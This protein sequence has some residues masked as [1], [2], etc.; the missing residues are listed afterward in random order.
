M[1]R[2]SWRACAALS[3]LNLATAVPAENP[4]SVILDDVGQG[5][6]LAKTAVDGLFA[7]MPRLKTAVTIEVS[8]LISRTKVEQSFANPHEL[9]LEALYVFPLPEGVVV[10]TLKLRVGDREI[11]GEIEERSQAQKSYEAAKAAGQRAALVEQAR[12][13]LFTTA[14]ANL[15]PGE[16]VTVHLEY[17]ATLR[18]DSGLFELRFPMTVTPRY[19]AAGSAVL[20]QTSG[21]ASPLFESIREL[22]TELSRTEVELEVDLG[23]P[24]EHVESPSHQLAIERRRGTNYHIVPFLQ[25]GKNLPADRDLVI[26]LRPERGTMPRVALY[27]ETFGRDTY[28]ELLVIPP[29][30][31]VVSGVRL[32]RETIFILDTSGSMSGE[33]LRA[34]KAAL[35]N[36]LGRLPPADH[37]NVIDFDS[38]ATRAFEASQPAEAEA[39][40]EAQAFIE[41]LEA[42]GGT[43]MLAALRLALEESAPLP[44]ALQ[45]IIFITDGSVDNEAA[46]FQYL[47]NRLGPARLFTVGIG[48][49]PNS[50]FLRRAAE[51]GRGTATFITDLSDVESRMGLLLGKLE[52]PLLAD[53][54]VLWYDP[55]TQSLPD[56]IPDLYHGEPLL[57]SARSPGGKS[58]LRLRGRYDGQAWEIEVS[59]KETRPGRGLHKLWAARQ[60]QKLLDS[61]LEGVPAADIRAQVVELGLKHHLITPFTSL[62]A[63]EQEPKRPTD[64]HLK[65]TV[66]P[67]NAPAGWVPPGPTAMPQTGSSAR[68]FLA[69][70]FLTLLVALIMLRRPRPC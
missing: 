65:S 2:W 15:G 51:A 48:S 11:V 31:E 64:A 67:L 47:R 68:L 18:Y 36:A 8:G 39:I 33:A 55:E 66:L 19:Q 60:V 30:D 61:R 27:Q 23:M 52:R 49:A 9:W 46:I 59:A 14:I 62:I 44:G 35:L 29:R 4:K 53:L 26:Y 10:D 24:L 1:S 21:A 43:E 58:G 22:P 40:A 56:P 54:E 42:D 45:Q 41:E 28:F 16:V 20:D 3:L 63:I 17:Q 34:A 25:A 5:S 37:F 69:L 12:P 32:P 50:Y 57:L 13:N 38:S 6:L 7:E 70:G